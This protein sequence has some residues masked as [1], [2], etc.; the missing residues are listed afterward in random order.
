MTYNNVW[1]HKQSRE[2]PGSRPNGGELFCRGRW[3]SPI[4]QPRSAPL[5][6]AGRRTIEEREKRRLN[7]K[8]EQNK[9]GIVIFWT[10]FHF[11]V[12]SAMLCR[13]LWLWLILGASSSVGELLIRSFPRA[14]AENEQ[15]VARWLPQKW[16]RLSISLCVYKGNRQIRSKRFKSWGFAL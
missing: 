10:E 1:Y 4:Y 12:K 15:F 14:C 11:T 13:A 16:S 5:A 8:E 6:T 9:N 2:P 3:T 7:S